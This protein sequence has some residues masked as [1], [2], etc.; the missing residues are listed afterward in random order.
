MKGIVTD[1]PQDCHQA[2]SVQW[3]SGAEWLAAGL[4]VHTSPVTPHKT[5]DLIRGYG[6]FAATIA[7]HRQPR[8]LQTKLSAT[9]CR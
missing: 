5:F 7:D 9:P 2:C 6:P 1:M 4:T 8:P 3:R